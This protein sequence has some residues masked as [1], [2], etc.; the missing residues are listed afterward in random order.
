[1][2]A[3]R[4]VAAANL[5]HAQEVLR[6]AEQELQLATARELEAHRAYRLLGDLTFGMYDRDTELQEVYLDNELV[7]Y[8]QGSKSL[9]GFEFEWEVWAPTQLADTLIY[10]SLDKARRA[11][12]AR[13]KELNK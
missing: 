7:G 9:G 3:E 2:S 12:R 13:L 8:I 10:P 11:L 6:R 5:Q 4:I 1:M